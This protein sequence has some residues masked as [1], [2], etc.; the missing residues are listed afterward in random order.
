M[1]EAVPGMWS[2]VAEVFL[3][4]THESSLQSRSGRGGLH[5]KSVRFVFVSAREGGQKGLEEKG[6]RT[7][8]KT[9]DYH[10]GMVARIVETEGLKKRCIVKEKTQYVKTCQ[11]SQKSVALSLLS[12]T[13][14]MGSLVRWAM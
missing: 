2:E 7:C 12:M 6:S 13:A 8:T 10:C 3:T 5:R 11:G 9:Q 1:V 4:Q 14:N